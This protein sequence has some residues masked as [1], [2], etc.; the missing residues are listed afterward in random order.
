MISALKDPVQ[1]WDFF[2][3]EALKASKECIG[4]PLLV[5]DCFITGKTLMRIEESCA[6]RVAGNH[7]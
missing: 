6:V 5:R 3:Q 4:K 7:D 2:R 1:L